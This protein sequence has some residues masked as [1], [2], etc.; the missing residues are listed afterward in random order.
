MKE[1][2]LSLPP[3]SSQPYFPSSCKL[4][5]KEYVTHSLQ[6]DSLTRDQKETR[7]HDRKSS[8]ETSRNVKETWAVPPPL[9]CFRIIISNQGS[10][11][12]HNKKCGNHFK[13]IPTHMSKIEYLLIYFEKTD[14][15]FWFIPFPFFQSLL[16]FPCQA[17][18]WI[19]SVRFIALDLYL[20][21]I[22]NQQ[23]KRLLF[24]FWQLFSCIWF[25][26]RTPS[27]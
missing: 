2:S 8:R 16:R 12:R 24:L 5:T 18:T 7:N 26:T 6:M 13:Q 14:F 1:T 3:P 9:L 10:H 23:Q 11:R 27:S 4:Y 20:I 15:L 17:K 19:T 22:L 25:V 21:I